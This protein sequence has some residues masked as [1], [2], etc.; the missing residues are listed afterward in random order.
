MIAE[1]HLIVFPSEEDRA[2]FVFLTG[3]SFS[4]VH[5]ESY[6]FQA[7]SKLYF[8]LTY[9]K[10]CEIPPQAEMGDSKLKGKNTDRGMTSSPVRRRELEKDA[11]GGV[12]H[13]TPTDC[14][15]PCLQQISFSEHSSKQ[16]TGLPATGK[17]QN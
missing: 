4:G 7:V 9:F 5:Y 6:I 2:W 11:L 8:M 12:A 13:I 15:N 10:A 17:T 1:F 14:T 3:H 16:I